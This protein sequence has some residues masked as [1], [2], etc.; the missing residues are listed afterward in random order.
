M[1]K[2][3]T[4]I[5]IDE[6]VKKQATELFGD[7]G[8]DISSAVNIFLRQ[9]VLRG[10]LPFEVIMP[11]YKPEVVEAMKEAKSISKDATV[12]GYTDIEETF[13]ELDNE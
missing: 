13:R 2:I 11:Q 8:L 4:Q 7:L 6:D 3:P 9:S 12:K 1:A 5:R 10:G